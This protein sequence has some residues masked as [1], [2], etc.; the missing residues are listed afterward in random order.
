[1]NGQELFAYR[2][3]LNKLRSLQIELAD[4]ENFNPFKS[5]SMD[6]MPHGS[7]SN[8]LNDWYLAEKDR[9]LSEIARC[10]R[11]V[12]VEKA[13]L[14][15]IIADAP[16]PECDIIRFKVV[17]NMSWTDIGDRIGYSP[18]RV[19]QLFWKYIEKI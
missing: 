12:E 8:D 6:G 19:S 10:K 16:Y 9:L 18:R 11:S 7:S 3:A 14:D 1:M 13:K 2:R 17:N 4:H 5:Q 15:R